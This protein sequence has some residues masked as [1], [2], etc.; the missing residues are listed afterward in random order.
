MH[1]FTHTLRPYT[2]VCTQPNTEEEEEE[3]KKLWQM[4]CVTSLAFLWL[5]LRALCSVCRSL[6]CSHSWSP[7]AHHTYKYKR[8][9]FSTLLSH[10]ILLCFSNKSR[11]KPVGLFNSALDVFSLWIYLFNGRDLNLAPRHMTSVVCEVR[12]VNWIPAWWFWLGSC[13][14]QRSAALP[15]SVIGLQDLSSL[16]LFWEG[17]YSFPLS[18]FMTPPPHPSPLLHMAWTPFVNKHQCEQLCDRPGKRRRKIK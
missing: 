5:R 7:S 1:I 10:A 11:F 16:M 13:W 18:L 14:V 3:E 15:R 6:M 2:A 8:L 4:C 12:C 9:H 17:N